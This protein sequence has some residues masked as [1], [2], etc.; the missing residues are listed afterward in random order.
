MDYSFIEEL[1]I[2]HWQSLSTLLFDGWV[3]RFADGVTKRANSV[4]PLYA[5]S[6]DLDYKIQ[7]CEN[8][9]SAHHLPTTFKVTPF[10]QPAH[11][12]RI[13]EEKGYSLAD[14]CCIQTLKLDRLPEPTLTNVKIEEDNAPEWME[15]FCRMNSVSDDKKRIMERMLSSIKTKKGFI[16][17]Y[18]GDQVVACGLGV[19]ER[20][21]IGLYDIV[22]DKR[23]RNQGFGEQ[24][25]LNLLQWGRENGAKYSYLQVVCSN[26]PALKLYAKLGFTEAYKY[27]YRVK[28]LSGRTGHHLR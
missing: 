2:N 10:T 28:E 25:I 11:L 15:H 6:A 5:S 27:W 1:S 21:Y 19:M 24:M 14:M 13:L 3:L 18:N 8:I 26:A 20:E 23:Y 4:N 7:E 12:D 9:Y 17:L 16:S 22:T